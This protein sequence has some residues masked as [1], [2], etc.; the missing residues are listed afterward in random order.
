[1]LYM[2]GFY[3][4]EAKNCIQLLLLLYYFKSYDIIQCVMRRYGHELVF[5]SFG[6]RFK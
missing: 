5:G 1:M 4:Y 6:I 2:H 3:V